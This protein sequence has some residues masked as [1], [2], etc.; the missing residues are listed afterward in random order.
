MPGESCSGPWTEENLET[1][2]SLLIAGVITASEAERR[3]NI[4]KQVL[5]RTIRPHHRSSPNLPG[6][7]RRR[8]RLQSILN[9]TAGYFPSHVTWTTQHL[10]KATRLA[11]IGLVSTEEAAR[12]FRVP[13][14]AVRREYER[15]MRE[16]NG[17]ES[18]AMQ[19]R[20]A[21]RKDADLFKY[22]QSFE[23]EVARLVVRFKD[24]FPDDEDLDPLAKETRDKVRFHVDSLFHILM[25]EAKQ[26]V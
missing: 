20:G 3:F 25:V 13:A 1:A 4:P 19:N 5:L 16:R 6:N 18:S 9:R 10:R 23:E 21:E 12:R 11:V 24:S 22:Y 14:E 2:R 15:C 26:N 7:Y 8:E 17:G